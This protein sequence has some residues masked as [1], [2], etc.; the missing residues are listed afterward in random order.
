MPVETLQTTIDFGAGVFGAQHVR[1]HVGLGGID[2]GLIDDFGAVL[3]EGRHRHTDGS[4]AITRGVADH[5]NL[6]R[7]EDIEA[8]IAGGVVP[9]TDRRRHAE[10]VRKFL[11][12]DQALDHAGMNVRHLGAG[13][14]RRD[15]QRLARIERPPDRVDLDLADQF[16]GGVD[17]LG[18]IALGVAHDDLD[19]A[20]LDAAGGVDGIRGEVHAAVEAD[21][22]RRTR[23]GHRG[24]TADLDRF[25]L[26]DRRFWKRKCRGAQRARAA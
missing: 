25:G 5:G 2:V 9:L 8:I 13:H 14:D 17:R 4:H 22:R 12:V 18:R 15:G 26:C 21:G 24:K 20:A 3:L 1:G 23:P 16:L 19:L 7:L 6:L 11:G 10:R